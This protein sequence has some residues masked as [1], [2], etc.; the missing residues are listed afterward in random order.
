MTHKNKAER[1]LKTSSFFF[2]SRFT[3]L[4]SR[5]QGKHDVTMP[6]RQDS[7]IETNSEGRKP[8]KKKKRR[9][10][11]IDHLL[12]IGPQNR[13]EVDAFIAGKSKDVSGMAP[14]LLPSLPPSSLSFSKHTAR[15]KKRRQSCV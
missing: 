7:I 9:E 6:L 3:H 12:L 13:G 1:T 10:V 4:R 15:K 2:P 8:V 11:E 14:I 5:K